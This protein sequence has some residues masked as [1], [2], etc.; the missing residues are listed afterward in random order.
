MLNDMLKASVQYGDFDG[1]AAAD[2]HDRRGLWDLAKKYGVDIDKYFVFGIDIF[3]GEALG[4]E[5]AHA[6]VS[7]LAIDT[8]VV[9]A[10]S[11]DSIQE[12]VDN[13]QGVLPY[14]EFGIDANLEEVLRFFKQ[15]SVVLKNSHI[16]RVSQYKKS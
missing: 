7:I 8:Q 5:P 9:G 1:T 14:V 6:N 16:V 13:N 11:V 3:V 4:D 2:H 12:Y 10:N 15:F